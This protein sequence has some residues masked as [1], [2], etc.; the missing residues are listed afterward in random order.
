MWTVV[1]KQ[2][3]W[4]SHPTARFQIC[5][6][7]ESAIGAQSQILHPSKSTMSMPE[8]DG[9]ESI[10]D[11]LAGGILSTPTMGGPVVET[12]ATCD[13]LMA[14]K[15]RAPVRW[16]PTTIVKIHQQEKEQGLLRVYHS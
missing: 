11:L 12:T 7:F 14:E 2:T 16:K 6:F 4:I 10:N 13:D 9:D 5:L 3:N 8:S 1:I 15:P